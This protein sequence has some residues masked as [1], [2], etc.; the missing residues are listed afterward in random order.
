MKSG[1]AAVNFGRCLPNGHLDMC[2]EN[3]HRQSLAGFF[4]RCCF[5]EKFQRLPKVVTCLLDRIPLAGNVKFGTQRY[6]AIA[7]LLNN[8]SQSTRHAVF[9]LLPLWHNKLNSPV[10]GELGVQKPRPLRGGTLTA[11]VCRPPRFACLPSRDCRHCTTFAGWSIQTSL[12]LI[13][14]RCGRREVRRSGS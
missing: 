14:A 11:P 12:P 3:I 4:R 5:K 13:P 10:R 2:H 9:P 8:R 7:V 1:V 6:I